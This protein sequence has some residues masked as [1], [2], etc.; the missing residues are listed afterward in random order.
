MSTHPPIVTAI[1]AD[2]LADRE[3]IANHKTVCQQMAPE[4]WTYGGYD[5]GYYLFQKGDYR[6]GFVL[7]ELLQ[8]DLTPEN[9]AFMARKGLTR[10]R[11]FD[12]AAHA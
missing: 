3:P 5:E 7:M 9:I 10:D 4:G 12:H 11:T 6:T 1:A 2:N 8:E